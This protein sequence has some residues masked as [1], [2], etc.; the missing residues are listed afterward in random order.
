MDLY[1]K[2]F[3]KKTCA[4]FN[5]NACTRKWSSIHSWTPFRE[6]CRLC[7]KEGEESNVIDHEIELDNYRCQS[8]DKFWQSIH[9]DDEKSVQK[10]VCNESVSADGVQ[11]RFVR[12]FWWECHNGCAVEWESFNADRIFTQSCGGCGSPGRIVALVR[13]RLKP[14]VPAGTDDKKKD[15]HG[16]HITDHCDMCQ[17]LLNSGGPHGC[18]KARQVKCENMQTKDGSTKLKVTQ[19]Q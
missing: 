11:K 13:R 6:Y 15:E 5:C 14:K 17:H 18:I 3:Y 2:E 1:K 16:T 4:L 10:C 7:K 12:H 9:H 8:C 19:V